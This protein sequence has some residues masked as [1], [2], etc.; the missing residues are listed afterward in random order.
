MVDASM[1]VASFHR[2]LL[3][4]ERTPGDV[5]S[6][7]RTP[8]LVRIDGVVHVGHLALIGPRPRRICG[9]HEAHNGLRVLTPDGCPVVE[10]VG[11]AF[12]ADVR[13]PNVRGSTAERRSYPRWHRIP[14]RTHVCPA[15]RVIR[16]AALAD[17]DRS[18][19]GATFEAR[20]ISVP[21]A[22]VHNNAR[23]RHVNIAGQGERGARV[24]DS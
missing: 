21:A 2:L 16:A 1:P 3:A 14:D 24:D 12:L 9:R 19:A 15:V 7:I 18:V 6:I 22:A 17:R 23:I 13:C 4:V 11:A 20:R 10:V 8:G 5:L